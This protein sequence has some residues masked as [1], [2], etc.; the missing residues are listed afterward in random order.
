MEAVTIALTVRLVDGTIL[1]S[2]LVSKEEV[3][4]VHMDVTDTADLYLARV[5]TE[6]T[7]PEGE[8][9][10]DWNVVFVSANTVKI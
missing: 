7:M 2:C 3:E 1:G 10:T 9:R 6:A 4:F 8:A 5:G